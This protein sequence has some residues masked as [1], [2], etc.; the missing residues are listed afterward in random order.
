VLD[1]SFDRPAAPRSE[2]AY[3]AIVDVGELMPLG[4]GPLGERRIIPILGGEFEGPG[5]R[6]IV[7]PGGA[8]RQLIRPDGL[9]LLDA[10]YEMKTDDG[11]ILTVRN[12]ARIRDGAPG[13]VP[14]YAFSALEVTAPEGPYD[15]LNQFVL[16]GT[17]RTQRPAR[18][19]VLISVFKLV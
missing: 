1:T 14:V 16:V 9:R 8:D 2:F 5:L 3:E 15:W 10:F 6:G 18:Q 13:S 19:A 11:A 7:L 17:V 4:R 12:R